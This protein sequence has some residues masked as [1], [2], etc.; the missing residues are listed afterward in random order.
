MGVTV[1]HG[2]FRTQ[3]IPQFLGLNIHKSLAISA[4]GI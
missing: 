3:D 1:K 4:S 2:S